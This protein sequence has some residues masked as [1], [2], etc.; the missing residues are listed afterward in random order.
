MANIMTQPKL[1]IIGT[2]NIANFHCDAFKKAGF[3]ISHGAG[4]LNSKSAIEF[5]K[6][7]GIKKIFSDPMEILKNC[8]QWDVVLLSTPTEKNITYLDEIL[9]INKPALIEK[10]VATD[11][12]YLSQFTKNSFKKIRVAYNRRFY[13]TTQRAKNFIDDEGFVYAK[14]ELPETLNTAGYYNSVH[15]NSAHGID[16]LNYLFS[17]LEVIKNIH[18][19]NDI[20]RLVIL[21][22]SDNQIVNLIMNWNSPSNFSLSLE[23][24][25]KKFEMKPFED[26]QIFQGMTVIEPSDELPLRRYVPKSIESVTSYPTKSNLI[27]PGFLEQALEIKNLLAGKEPII[28]ASLYDAFL[29]QKLVKA[30]LY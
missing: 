18:F 1:A 25:N 2:G 16:L 20:G 21:K 5:G 17:S 27:K 23:S 9:K 28:S 4:S 11:A 13:A 8:A 29:A 15:L 26:S 22:S 3:E 7:H 12:E 14:M 19:E 24:A 10:P 6:K 30:I